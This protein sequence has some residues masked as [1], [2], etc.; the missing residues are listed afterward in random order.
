MS[1]ELSIQGMHCDGCVRRV[2]KILERAGTPAC[3]EVLGALYA[4][5]LP[6]AEV[7]MTPAK[8]EDVLLRVLRSGNGGAA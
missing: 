8:L 7:N 2:K 3:A 1:V 5:G 4:A 6:V